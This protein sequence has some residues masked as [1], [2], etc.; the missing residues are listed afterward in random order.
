MTKQIVGCACLSAVLV[1]ASLLLPATVFSRAEM[2]KIPHGLP[3]SFVWQSVVKLDPPSFPRSYTVMLPQEYPTW[4][5]FPRL[6]L[7]I[8]LVAAIV[9][10]ALLIFRRWRAGIHGT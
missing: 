5:S 8:A 6:A 9:F 3:F 7:N 2:G 1:M 10:L 4:V